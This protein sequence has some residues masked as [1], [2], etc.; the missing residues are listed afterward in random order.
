MRIIYIH[1]YFK[2]PAEGGAT[3]SY[4]LAKGL[5]DAGYDVEVITGGSVH[6]DLKKMEGFTVH[7]L[8]V[9]YAQRF[10]FVRR[11]FAFFSFVYRAKKLIQKLPRPDLFYISS[12]PL[13]TGWIG[14]WAKK[15][16]AVPYIF[17]VR[18]IWPEAPIQVGVIR[19]PLLIRFLRKQEKKIY[20]HALQLVG[21]SPGMVNHMRKLCPKKEIHLIPNFSD[22]EFFAPQKKR[23]SDLQHFGLSGQLTLAYTGALGKVNAV[24]ELIEFAEFVRDRGKNWQFLIMGEG[25]EKEKLEAS[26]REK[27]LDS[28]HFVPFGSKDEVQRVLSVADFAWI[29]FADLPILSTNSPNK[30][31]DALAAGKGILINH[32]GWVYRLV[33]QNRLGLSVLNRDWPRLCAELEELERNPQRLEQFGKNSR[34]V[35]EGFFTA[36]IAVRRLLH[37]IDPKAHPLTLAHEAYI[38][39]A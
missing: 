9:G 31:F 22:S 32:K 33:K 4:Y 11:V 14:L 16:F 24:E 10:G 12:T 5:A 34:T 35:F 28:V 17:E 18:D 13:T 20:T 21:L 19:N 15:R 2:T 29:S 25:S 37:V 3:R 1:Q 38:R 36:E 7:Y 23:K 39:I 30:F 6:Y 8:P 27:N 26:A